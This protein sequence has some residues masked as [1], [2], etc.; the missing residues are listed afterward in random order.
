MG[1][2]LPADADAAGPGSTLGV[3]MG[4]SQG[5]SGHNTTIIALGLKKGGGGGRERTI[6]FG[7]G[8]D[9]SLW[10]CFRKTGNHPHH[11]PLFPQSSRSGIRPS[12]STLMK[13]AAPSLTLPIS[14][15]FFALLLST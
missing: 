3:A 15:L 8:S 14:L 4:L 9:P 2:Q 5:V 11:I 10:K 13:I 1:P 6:A 7:I 12:L